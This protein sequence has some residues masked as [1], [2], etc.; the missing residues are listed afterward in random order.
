MQAWPMPVRTASTSALRVST[1]FAAAACFAF[2]TALRLSLPAL[3][4]GRSFGSVSTSTATSAS[5]CDWTNRVIRSCA[6]LALSSARRAGSSEPKAA[7]MAPP[8]P[9]LSLGL[10]LFWAVARNS[11]H[12][13]SVR[14][15]FGGVQPHPFR[16][17]TARSTIGSSL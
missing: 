17:G 7:V 14:A 13:F 12:T 1:I 5:T 9:D 3:A 6:A 16:L 2:N 4:A 10:P 15:G 8:L 11:V